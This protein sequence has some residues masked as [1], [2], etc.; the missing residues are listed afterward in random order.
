MRI[1][2]INNIYYVSYFHQYIYYE[3]RYNLYFYFN[4]DVNNV[5]SYSH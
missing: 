5:I 1:I 3:Q 2:I 4:R